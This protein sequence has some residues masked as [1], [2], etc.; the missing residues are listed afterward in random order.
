LSNRSNLTARAVALA[1]VLVI[2]GAACGKSSTSNTGSGSKSPASSK[3]RGGYGGGGSS[4]SGG[5]G[6]GAVVATVTQAN[7][8]FT[9]AKVTVN[10]GDTISVKNGN[11]TTPHTFTVTGQGIDITN[12]AGQSQDVT[13][14]LAPGTYTFICRFHESQGMKGTLIVN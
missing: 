2:A 11:P 10:K 8:V 5:G 14:D 4:S 12:D 3:P 6:G 1:A 13:I 7:F 9:P